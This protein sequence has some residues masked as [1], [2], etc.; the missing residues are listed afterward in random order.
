MNISLPPYNHDAP[1]SELSFSKLRAHNHAY[2]ANV[3]ERVHY[4]EYT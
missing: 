3:K 2:A 1:E 4:H